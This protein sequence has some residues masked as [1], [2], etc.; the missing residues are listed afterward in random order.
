MKLS[1]KLTL[2]LKFLEGY[3]I[4]TLHKFIKIHLKPLTKKYS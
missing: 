3:V 4:Q 2:L 1:R